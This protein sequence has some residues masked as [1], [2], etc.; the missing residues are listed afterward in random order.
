[1][2]CHR[3]PKVLTKSWEPKKGKL[4][5]F[6]LEKEELIKGDSKTLFADSNLF[7]QK[8]EDFYNRYVETPLNHIIEQSLIDEKELTFKNFVHIRASYLLLISLIERSKH[9]NTEKKTVDFD[10]K[11]LMNLCPIYIIKR[12]KGF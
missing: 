11:K 1:M 8:E 3:I 9:I 7:S 2:I 4:T 12:V 5:Y 6:C 10:K